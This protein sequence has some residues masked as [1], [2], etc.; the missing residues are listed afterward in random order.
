MAGEVTVLRRP[1]RHSLAE[2]SELARAPLAAAGAERAV[3][4]GS[5]A[6]GEADG[7]S[8]LDLAVVLETELPFAERGALLSDLLEAL[9]VGVDLLVYSPEEYA[10]GLASR[11]G[12]FEAI[13]REGVTIH[14]RG[15][16]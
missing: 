11:R 1:L 2:L 15:E 16:S 14:A 3:V 5:Y 12:V 6:R 9:P 7:Y 10:R 8:D 13:A 4:F